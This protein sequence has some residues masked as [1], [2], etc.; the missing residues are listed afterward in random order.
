M[1]VLGFGTC[2]PSDEAMLRADASTL[3]CPEMKK[4][5]VI[6][7][8]ALGSSVAFVQASAVTLALPSLQADLG[9]TSLQLQWVV[10]TYLLALG[11]L[12]LVGGAMGDRY[13][14]RRTF[15]FGT[16]VFAFGALSCA[17]SE[18]LS[19][20]LIA[21]LV[22]GA[23]AALLVP[24][25]L[26][27]IS[28]YFGKEEKGRAIGIWAGA[29]AL[30]TSIS[31]VIGGWCVDRWGWRS[32]FVLLVPIA[33][34][35]IAMAWRHVPSGAPERDRKLDYFG[36]ILL[37]GA[38]AASL[39]ALFAHRPGGPL[40]LFVLS[41]GVLGVFLWREERTRAPI[42]PLRLFRSRI[43]VGANVMT[44]LLYAA[45]SGAF[46][47]L[48]F[49]LMQVHGYSAVEA[50]AALLPMTV[51]LGVGSVFAG[52]AMRR[53]EARTLL[54][55][56]SLVCAAGFFALAAPGREATYVRDYLPALAILGL[57]MTIS[58]APLTTVV[59]GSVDAGDVGLASGVDNTMAR[60]AGAI[61][62]AGLTA[63][64]IW[65][66]S[67]ALVAALHDAGVP[68][69]LAAQ[70]TASASQLAGLRA[71]P[72]VGVHMAAAINASVDNAYVS[73]FRTLVVVCGLSALGS[74]LAAWVSLRSV[75]KPGEKPELRQGANRKGTYA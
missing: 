69:A 9:L 36:A 39:L 29:S 54:A 50:G 67:N 25:S 57:G 32:V 3:P 13:G 4:K 55:I 66:F 71:P 18:S 37:A 17:L 26:A 10:N 72:N 75:G 24:T 38:M 33:L 73:T 41:L 19:L 34:L 1:T 48:P 11:T 70:L 46:Y 40:D 43:F 27:L 45:F 47:F 51:L 12:M 44:C 8:S 15:I 5:W 42:L 2:Q 14:L 23:G 56:G 31:P 21:R 49:D 7:T 64:A 20:L 60:L 65:W 68:E 63:L 30:T 74:A 28:K 62:V 58:V 52:A 6:A 61:A 22:E 16:A 35:A 53:I 59:M